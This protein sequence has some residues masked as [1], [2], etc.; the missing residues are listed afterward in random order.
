MKMPQGP[1]L[2]C[3]ERTKEDPDKGTRDCHDRCER[4]QK[5]KTDLREFKTEV[6]RQKG[7]EKIATERP[8]LNPQKMRIAKRR[9]H[10]NEERDVIDPGDD[11]RH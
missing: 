8:W 11:K 5:Y 1:C 3:R 10:D 6:S 9:A 4:Y 7:A 2:H